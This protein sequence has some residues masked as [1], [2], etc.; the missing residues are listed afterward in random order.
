VEEGIVMSYCRFGWEGSNV[1]VY[2]SASGLECCGCNLLD[3]GFTAKEPEEMIAHLGAHRRANQYVPEDAILALWEDIPGAQRSK[4]EDPVFTKPSLEMHIIQL[5]VQLARL[6][7][8]PPSEIEKTV[9]DFKEE[10][11]FA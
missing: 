6:N 8:A 9:S 1:Y 5:Q 3:G 7:Q 11:P 2:E 4:G 10:D